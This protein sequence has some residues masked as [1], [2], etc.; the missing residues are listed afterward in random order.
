MNQTEE[1]FVDWFAIEIIDG[2][3]VILNASETGL[4]MVMCS[5]YVGQKSPGRLGLGDQV[6]RNRSTEGLIS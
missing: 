5:A 2:V 6:Q 4:Q 1:Q 3:G